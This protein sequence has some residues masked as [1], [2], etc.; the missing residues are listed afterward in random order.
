MDDR[1]GP[2]LTVG[3]G[4]LAGAGGGASIDAAI[5][6]TLDGLMLSRLISLFAGHLALLRSELA[7]IARDLAGTLGA[8]ALAALLFA[9]GLISA[10]A[11]TVVVLTELLFGSSAFGLALLVLGPLLLSLLL[12]A[13]ALRIEG[14]ARAIGLALVSGSAFAAG[15]AAGLHVNL[16]GAIGWGLLVAN[17]NAL[18]LVGALLRRF[19]PERLTERM[20]PT[21]SIEEFERTIATASELLDEAGR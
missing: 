11:I 7:A 8:L 17:T 4:G 10:L 6:S 1:A 20:T 15:L 14:R 21:I 12:I 9:L 3:R 18:L 19:D 2:V 5:A 13:G 16:P